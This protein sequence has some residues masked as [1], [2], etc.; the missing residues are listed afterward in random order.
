MSGASVRYRVH[1]GVALVTIARPERMNALDAAAREGLLAAMTALDADEEAR[2]GVLTGEGVRAF[3]AGGDLAEEVTP[4]AMLR[5]AGAFGAD[6]PL[7]AAVNGVAYGAGFLLVQACD[8]VVASATARFAVPET[9]LGRSA[10][11][12]APLS[13]WI[14]PRAAMELLLTGDPIGARRAYELGLVNAVVPA[15]D[16]IEAAL[17]LAGRIAERAPLAVRAAKRMTRLTAGLAGTQVESELAEIWRPVRE[18]RDAEE[19]VAAFREKRSP[20]WTGR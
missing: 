13:S 14:P 2:V 3:C 16:L 17:A 19:G 6:K 20:R 8:L 18:S 15:A 5:F 11:W 4:E 7:V 10:A 12:A 9:K 1:D